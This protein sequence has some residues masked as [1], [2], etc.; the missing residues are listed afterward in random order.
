MMFKNEH[1]WDIDWAVCSDK[2]LIHSANN[3]LDGLERKDLLALCEELASRLLAS[4]DLISRFEGMQGD[5]SS[6]IRN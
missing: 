1:K 2:T 3:A 5:S 4:I 6:L